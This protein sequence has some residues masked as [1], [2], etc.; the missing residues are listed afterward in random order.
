MGLARLLNRPETVDIAL[1][2]LEKEMHRFQYTDEQK[3]RV[4]LKFVARASAHERKYASVFRKMFAKQRDEVLG[5]MPAKGYQKATQMDI[6]NWMFDKPRWN[7]RFSEA[8][9][10]LLPMTVEEVGSAELETL[11]VGVAFDVSDPRVWQFIE[12]RKIKLRQVNDTTEDAIRKALSAGIQEGEG[13]PQ[14]RKRI[15]GVFADASKN[16]ATMIARSE[17]IRASNFAAEQAYI[18]SGVVEGKEWLT[19]LDERTCPWCEEMNGKTM[20][21]GQ[22]FFALGEQMTVDGRTIHFDYDEV[23]YPPLHPD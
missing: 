8:G 22:N 6:E 11:I 9:Q 16:R 15:Q 5:N 14:L 7:V 23:K 18:Q 21:L 17:T 19:A 12:K 3:E 10:L 20:A 13:I 4:W 1:T 2:F